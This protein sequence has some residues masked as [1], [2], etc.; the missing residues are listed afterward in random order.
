M[1]ADQETLGNERKPQGAAVSVPKTSADKESAKR[2]GEEKKKT[3]LERLSRSA[4][5]GKRK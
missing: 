4:T 1:K 5:A 3:K 2:K